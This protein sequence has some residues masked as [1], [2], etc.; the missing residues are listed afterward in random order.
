[1]SEQPKKPTHPCYICGN[2]DFW[3]RGSEWLC[4]RCHPKPGVEDVK[5]KSADSNN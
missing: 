3:L 5:I 1:M 4:V 2:T